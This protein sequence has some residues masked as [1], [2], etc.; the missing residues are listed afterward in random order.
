MC[1]NTRPSAEP[2]PWCPL[3]VSSAVPAAADLG[4]SRR[5]MRKP[6]RPD[7]ADKMMKATSVQRCYI[8]VERSA[9]RPP[10][11]SPLCRMCVC[12]MYSCCTMVSSHVTITSC[13]HCASSSNA[14]SHPPKP[15]LQLVKVFEG[16]CWYTASQSYILTSIFQISAKMITYVFP[17]VIWSDKQCTWK[18]TYSISKKLKSIFDKNNKIDSR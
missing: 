11:N 12:V 4:E 5:L 6:V 13:S 10:E 8:G 14:S 7:T 15:K 2:C 16:K 18:F 9:H 17:D 3:S 1:I